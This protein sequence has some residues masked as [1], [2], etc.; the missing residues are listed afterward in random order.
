M[1][2]CEKGS[3]ATKGEVTLVWSDKQQSVSP[4]NL[5]HHPYDVVAWKESAFQAVKHDAKL[6]VL[7]TR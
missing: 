6:L 1:W 4:G 7:E 2:M 5:H 3:A